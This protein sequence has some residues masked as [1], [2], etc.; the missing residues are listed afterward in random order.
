MFSQ[1]EEER[2]L[3]SIRQGQIARSNTNAIVRRLQQFL[4]AV[5]MAAAINALNYVLSWETD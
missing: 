3:Q 1:Y 2:K 5:Q 4:D